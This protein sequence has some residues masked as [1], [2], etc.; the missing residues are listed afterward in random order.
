M[1]LRSKEFK[2]FYRL[3][4]ENSCVDLKMIGFDAEIIADDPLIGD[5]YAWTV[6]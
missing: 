6:A 2:G 5:P 1:R 4:V 3:I